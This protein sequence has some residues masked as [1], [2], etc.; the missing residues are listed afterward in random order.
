MQTTN[1]TA[2]IPQGLSS[3]DRRTYLAAR[4]SGAVLALSAG[5]AMTPMNADAGLG[6]APASSSQIGAEISV[7]PSNVWAVVGPFCLV[8]NWRPGASCAR[9]LA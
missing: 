3:S 6:P 9:Q 4:I 5:C 2:P 1:L 7:P 8:S